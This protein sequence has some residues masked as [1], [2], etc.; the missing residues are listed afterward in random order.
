MGHKAKITVDVTTYDL[1]RGSVKDISHLKE[2]VR[3][4]ATVAVAKAI[5]HMN[6]TFMRDVTEQYNGGSDISTWSLRAQSGFK[7]RGAPMLA[8]SPFVARIPERS[9]VQA[10]CAAQ[11]RDAMDSR[12]ARNAKRHLIEDQEKAWQADSKNA[13]ASVDRPPKVK[14]RFTTGKQHLYIHILVPI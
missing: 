7:D 8:D 9:E 11:G 3:G 10:Y 4:F 14:K 2:D 12:V 1:R 13:E 5:G 6:S